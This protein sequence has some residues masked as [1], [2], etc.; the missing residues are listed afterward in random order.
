M[1]PTREAT[2]ER[3]MQSR[4]FDT[5]DRTSMLRATIGVLQDLG[6]TIEE[7]QDG[8]GMIVASRLAGA[9]IRAQI[10]VRAVPDANAITVRANFQRTAFTAGATIARGETIADPSIYS[11]FF[12]KLAQSVFLTA[13]EI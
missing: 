8:F 13:H 1:T 3:A 7:S 6:Y 12:D 11:G 5:K 2:A 4:R 9:Q 10:V